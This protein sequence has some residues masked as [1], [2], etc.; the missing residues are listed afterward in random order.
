MS[1]IVVTKGN[2]RS[3]RAE[4][5]STVVVRGKTKTSP[6]VKAKR[7]SRRNGNTNSVLPTN[8]GG[9]IVNVLKEC[10]NVQSHKY[11]ALIKLVSNL[12]VLI[13]AYELIKSNTGNTTPGTT[14]ETLDGITKAWLEKLSAELAQ[15]RFEF[16]PSRRVWIPK[17]DGSLTRPL[18]VANP[19]E[20]IVQKAISMILEGIYEP[21]FSDTSHG[22]RPDRSCHSALHQMSLGVKSGFS[23]VIEGD[24][25]KCYD[26]IPHKIII[27]I[28]KENIAC[29]KF[30]TLIN[31]SLQAGYI[32]PKNSQIIKEKVG[33]PQGSV[34]SPI[35]CNIVLDKLDKFIEDLKEKFNRGE[36]RRIVPEYR[37]IQR[38]SYNDRTPQQKQMRAVDVMDPNFKRLFYVRYADD[39]IVA[40]LG[41]KEETEN[42]KIEIKEFLS[43]KLGL[44]LN[45]DKSKVTSLKKG[46]NFLG[47]EIFV[48]K[49][50][51]TKEQPRVKYQRNGK[52]I[53]AKF[54]PRI[55]MHA[56]IKSLLDKLVER[57]FIKAVNKEYYPIGLTRMF[58]HDHEDILRYYN[59]VINGIVNYYSFVDNRMNLSSIVRYLRYSCAATLSRKMKIP[60]IRQVFKR[61]GPELKSE[62]GDVRLDY[63]RSKDLRKITDNKKFKNKILLIQPDEILNTMWINKVTKSNLNKVCALCGSSEEIEMHHMRSVKDVRRKINKGEATF[64]EW[65]GAFLRKQVPLCNRH[66]RAWHS[67]T[68]SETELNILKTYK[69]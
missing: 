10:F 66:H 14:G 20:K 35:L 19:R 8:S 17:K 69:D 38:L 55:V 21:R 12:D 61:F 59:S 65:K 46:F 11:Q 36:A 58:T 63:P 16:K 24:I 29:E 44:T 9:F 18:G 33:T 41:S 34:L 7:T 62:T 56:P 68:L 13:M 15:G 28:L 26:S 52:N 39:F 54:H 27:E 42:L 6:S 50:N 22:F 1:Q 49:F 30:L 40:V 3:T 51:D 57:K 2:N 45:M 32:D 48:K 67:N 5:R 25:S 23:W 31:R 47:A 43:E 4:F 53:D 64:T 37:K 60:S